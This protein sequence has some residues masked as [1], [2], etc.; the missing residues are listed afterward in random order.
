[1]KGSEHDGRKANTHAAI[2]FAVSIPIV[3]ACVAMG[4]VDQMTASK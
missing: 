1:M 3:A 4:E 2:F